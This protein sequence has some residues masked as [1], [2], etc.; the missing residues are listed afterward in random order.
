MNTSLEICREDAALQMKRPK[1][2]KQPKKGEFGTHFEL[3]SETM[4]NLFIKCINKDQNE[5]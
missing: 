1:N 2:P 4:L 5:L 3:K